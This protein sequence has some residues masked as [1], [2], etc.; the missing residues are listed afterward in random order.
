MEEKLYE[1]AFLITLCL[2]LIGWGVWA[3]RTK[4]PGPSG[5]LCGRQMCRHPRSSHMKHS[6]ACMVTPCRCLHFWEGE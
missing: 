2:A 1:A 3:T 5:D 6:A 4:K